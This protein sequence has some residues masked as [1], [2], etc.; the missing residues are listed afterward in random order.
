LTFLMTGC[1]IANLS[2]YFSNPISNLGDK[3]Q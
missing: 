1:H 3:K 2:F